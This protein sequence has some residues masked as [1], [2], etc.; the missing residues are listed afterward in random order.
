ME[1]IAH[2]MVHLKQYAKGE[3]VDLSRCGST[4]WQNNLV[5]SQTNY[6]DPSWEI[7]GPW[8]GIRTIH[9][10]GRSKKPRKIQLDPRKSFINYYF[11]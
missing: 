3:L 10:M 9:Q 6:W 1:T 11:N 5:D 2:E 7:E 8:Q 4:R